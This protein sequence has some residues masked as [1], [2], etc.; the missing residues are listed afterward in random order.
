MIQKE[1][2][3]AHLKAFLL[4]VVFV[5][6]SSWLF[7]LPYKIVRQNTIDSLNAQQHLLAR[8]AAH[9][10][11]E[12]FR[13]FDKLL[14]HLALHDDI[15]HLDENGQKLLKEFLHTHSQTISAVTRVGPDGRI[16]YTLPYRPDAIGLDISSQ[17]HNR[18]I[19]E[20]HEPVVSKVF[21]AVQGYETVAYAIPVFDQ[22]EY[23]GCLSILIPF[24]VVAQRYLASII[25]GEN[26]YAWM[27]SRE[28][29][30]LYCPVPGHVGKTVHETSNVF[31]TVIAMAKKMMAGLQGKTTYIYDRVKGQKVERIVKHAVY[32]PVKLP[33]NSWSIVVATPEKQALAAIREFG[34][35]WMAIFAV[36]VITLLFYASYFIRTRLRLA[37]QQKRAE[38]EKELAETQKL[39]SKFINT[40]HVPIAMVNINGTIEY[41]NKKCEELYGYSLEEIP[42]MEE[43]FS[44]VYPDKKLQDVIITTWQKRVAEA[45]ANKVTMST[46]ERTIRCK[47]GSNKDVEF[48]YTLVEDRLIIT[49][50]DKT[51]EKQVKLEK[52]QLETRKAKAKK[53]EALGLLAGGV[54]HDLNNILSGIVSYPDLLLLKLPEE[55]EMRSS[56]ELIQKSGRE[57]AAVVADLLTVARGVANVRKT[58]DLNDLINEYLHSPE[59]QTI[60]AS[61]PNVY[62]TQ[63]LTSG[64]VN[65]FC[66]AVHVKKCLM[67]LMTN[68]A[69]AIAEEG[70]VTVGSRIQAVSSEEARKIG[71]EEGQFVVLTVRDT[72]GGIADEELDHAAELLEK[73]PLK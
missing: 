17:E 26:G 22:G 34:R 4:L 35:W 13:S 69:E 58:E 29:V 46:E 41:I 49:L 5:A 54:A 25:L 67:N 48:A 43:W 68:A 24:E 40:A 15:I 59:Y 57:A 38:A 65:I 36:F 52:E 71:V 10:I 27:I 56:I 37:E 16:Q 50:N 32:H 20:K 33:N 39:F 28:G 73:D 1:N 45:M 21:M 51:E 14:E 12:F 3:T 47:D 9:G 18:L 63:E 44:R 61:H 62:Y 60:A 19:I 42:T 30:E 2:L 55:S 64:P 66:S 23:A 53:M 72:G 8:Q 11:E 31:P 6:L 7:Y 70:C